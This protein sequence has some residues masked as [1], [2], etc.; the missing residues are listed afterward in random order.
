[1]NCLIGKVSPDQQKLAVE[2]DACMGLSDKKVQASK[3]LGLT[4]CTAL[5]KRTTASFFVDFL[6]SFLSSSAQGDTVSD[7]WRTHTAS[8][9]T[10]K[11]CFCH[12]SVETVIL[13]HSCLGTA[14]EQHTSSQIK[15]I[16]KLL[17]LGLVLQLPNSMAKDLEGILCAGVLAF[18]GVDHQR[19]LAIL[20]F[21]ILDV[22]V[23][24][25]AE[26]LKGVE[27]KRTKDPIDL[28]VPIHLPQLSEELLQANQH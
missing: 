25:Q 18:V 10:C 16:D 8:R 13:Q 14:A 4:L 6:R 5:A 26:L 9:H 20:A 7:R 12:I 1:M 28:V 19:R 22:G 11:L 15:H 17:E 23:K 3:G 24:G 21:D 2:T 27:L